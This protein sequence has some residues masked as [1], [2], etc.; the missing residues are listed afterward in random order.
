[1]DDYRIFNADKIQERIDEF[2]KESS[3]QELINKQYSTI[4]THKAFLLEELLFNSIP[5]IPEIE[6]AF[7]VGR[8]PTRKKVQ[9]YGGK[10]HIEIFTLKEDYIS[11]L[12]LDI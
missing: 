11:Q 1:M 12:K 2:Y 10:K 3:K 4:L 5:L 8:I 9:G 7:D 6:K